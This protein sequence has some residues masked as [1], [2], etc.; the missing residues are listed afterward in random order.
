MRCCVSLILPLLLVA[1]AAAE[2][3]QPAGITVSGAAD[4]A[5]A[6]ARQAGQVPNPSGP[7]PAIQGAYVWG[8]R[9]DEAYR[10]FFQW[11]LR[12]KAGAALSGLRLRTVTLMPDRT[13][14]ATGE[15]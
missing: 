14:A 10:P 1:L 15:W 11:E 2:P 4:A 5:A 3:K 13:P 7:V 12:L 9:A 8:G 6:F